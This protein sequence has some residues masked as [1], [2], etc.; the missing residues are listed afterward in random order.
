MNYLQ[1][2]SKSFNCELL[3]DK[4]R[5]NDSKSPWWSCV[6]C[7]NKLVFIDVMFDLLSSTVLT[8]SVLLF[9]ILANED[10]SCVLPLCCDGYF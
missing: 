6:F 9:N 1:D 4:F 8:E 5:F 10:P 3:S 2:L 7:S